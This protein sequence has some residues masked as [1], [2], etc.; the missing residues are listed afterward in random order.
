M[1]RIEMLAALRAWAVRRFD[2]HSR[3]GR[4]GALVVAS[5]T[6]SDRTRARPAGSPAPRFGLRSATSEC[7]RA[8]RSVE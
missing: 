5:R 4:H 7:S 1:R 3:Q 6:G 8:T 2:D